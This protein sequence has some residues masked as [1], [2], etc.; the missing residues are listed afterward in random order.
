MSEQNPE[1]KAVEKQENGNGK[2]A[3]L[4]PI[5]V[6]QK[7]LVLG[8]SDDMKRLASFLFD[9]QLA[10]PH[11]VPNPS[12]AFLVV[13]TAQEL[14]MPVMSLVALLTLAPGTDKKP[15]TLGEVI[16]KL[17]TGR[18]LGLCEEE[19]LSGIL[20]VNNRPSVWGDTMLALVYASGKCEYVKEYTEGQGDELTA[21][22][23][24]KRVGAPAPIVRKFSVRDAKRAGLWNKSGPWQNYPERMLTMRPRAFALRDG[25]A[26]VLRGVGMVE[27]MLG[28]PRPTFEPERAAGAAGLANRLKQA[29]IPCGTESQ[30]HAED[31][32]DAEPVITVEPVTTDVETK[33]DDEN[34]EPVPVGDAGEQLFE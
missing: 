4:A 17:R 31:N 32:Q 30:P 10:P 3:S 25:F 28:V 6:G 5:K 26:D 7:G 29:A 20:V 11:M 34:G 18:R 12:A 24:V 21:V 33:P 22:C 14:E 9:S 8:D 13:Q 19:A 23:E 15:A 16:I 2:G 1:Q 27:E